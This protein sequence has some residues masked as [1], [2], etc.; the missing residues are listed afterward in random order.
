MADTPIVRPSFSQDD[1]LVPESIVMFLQKHDYFVLAGHMEPDGDCTGSMLALKHYL[2]RIGKD[3]GCYCVGP[4]NR[5]EILRWAY[6]FESEYSPP[7]VDT[8]RRA[9]IILDCSTPERIGSLQDDIR[10]L[11][12]AVIDH[13]AS[14]T[15]FG[16]TRFVDPTAPS[17]TYLIQRI[18][19]TMT[20]SVDRDEAEYLLFGLCTDTGFF[21]HVDTHGERVLTAAGRLTRAGTSLNNIHRLIYGGR[22]IGTRLLL[23][24]L[25]S[26]TRVYFG[27]AV[28]FTYETIS[29]I[30]EFGVS[31]RD[32]D[33]LYQL[34]QGTIGCRAVALFRDEEPGR[35]SVGLRSNDDLDVG[36]IAKAFGGGG[37]AK[38]A[39]FEYE[40]L[41]ETLEENLLRAFEENL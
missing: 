29:D 32:S 20:G 27:G 36:S 28:L 31:A 12:T 6:R 1:I 24:R 35:L 25:L 39:G 22:P 14:G 4:F 9:A 8:R 23:G 18:I 11:P 19:E 3:A 34:L 15:T 33:T 38:A 16:D 40:G 37:H 2:G 13:H 30:D 41:R 26:R 7:A 5:P 21:R 10:G 17:V